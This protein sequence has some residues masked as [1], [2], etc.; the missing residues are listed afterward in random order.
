[1]IYDNIFWTSL[2]RVLE[3]VATLALKKLFYGPENLIK[4]DV[5]RL[6]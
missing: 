6:Y 3:N 2:N 4:N 5:E 1:M